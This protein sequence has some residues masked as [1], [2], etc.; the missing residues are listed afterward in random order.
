MTWYQRN[1]RTAATYDMIY[2][3][4]A[5]YFGTAGLNN[6][7]ADRLPLALHRVWATTDRD[8][9]RFLSVARLAF[10]GSLG[11]KWNY[12]AGLSRASSKSESILRSGFDYTDALRTS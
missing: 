2:N 9:D 10:E 5:A 11:S 3:S 1:A 8:H 7:R 12:N 4:L 6:R